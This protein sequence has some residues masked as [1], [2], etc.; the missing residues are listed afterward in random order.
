MNTFAILRNTTGHGLHHPLQG[1]DKNIII[2]AGLFDEGI[3]AHA[4][5]HGQN[6]IVGT[7]FSVNGQAV[8]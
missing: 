5:G 3:T 2:R 6:T 7:H 8:Q 1:L 4:I